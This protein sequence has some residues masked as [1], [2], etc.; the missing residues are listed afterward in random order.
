MV[1]TSFIV[2]CAF[3]P[4]QIAPTKSINMYKYGPN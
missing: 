4:A 3:K 1:K 2:F